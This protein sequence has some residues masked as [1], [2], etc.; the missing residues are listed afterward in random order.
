MTPDEEDNFLN[1]VL[2]SGQK[3]GRKRPLEKREVERKNKKREEE[4]TRAK[5][6]GGSAVK[7]ENLHKRPYKAHCQ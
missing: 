4:A 6:S 5:E 2:R 1:W 3:E 7:K